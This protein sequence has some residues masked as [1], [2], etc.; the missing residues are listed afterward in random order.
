MLYEKSAEK[1]DSKALMDLGAMAEKGVGTEKDPKRAYQLYEKAASMGNPDA[2][3][4]L[5]STGTNNIKPANAINKAYQ[6]GSLEAGKI[7]NSTNIFAPKVNRNGN[8]YAET[9][10]TLN[11]FYVTKNMAN[12]RA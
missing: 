1:G 6:M 12:S 10:K 8:S 3:I 9:L 7:L 4:V 2:L 5:S 11:N